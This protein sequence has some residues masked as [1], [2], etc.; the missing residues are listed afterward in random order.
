VRA[1]AAGLLV[2]FGVTAAW[3]AGASEPA[4]EP[5]ELLLW[6]LSRGASESYLLGTCHLG[7][8]LEHVLPPPHDAALSEASVVVTEV[9]LAAVRPEAMLAQA[10]LPDG[11]RLS[12]QVGAESWRAL[13][14][15]ARDVAPAP[16][17]DRLKPW[18]V[19]GA[20][21]VGRDE[22][23]NV[24][25]V[26]VAVIERATAAG[27]KLAY[28]ETPEEQVALMEQLGSR[29]F[30][31][32]LREIA[33]GVEGEERLLLR[34]ACVAGDL[35]AVEALVDAPA[36]GEHKSALYE[37]R[38][39]A[40]MPR[41]LGHLQGGQAFVAVGAGHLVG[42]RGLLSLL[43]R[44]GFRLERLSAPAAP[45]PD[46]WAPDRRVSS[47]LPPD[48][49][50]ARAGLW[51]DRLSEGFPEGVC[52][53]Q[54]AVRSCIVEDEAE[55]VLRVREGLA[56][57]VDQFAGSLPSPQE[58]LAPDLV[59]RLAGCAVSGLIAE[60]AVRGAAVEAPQCAA[61]V[62]LLGER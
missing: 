44:R 53:E 55:C 18:V 30:V 7:I 46:V 29:L 39:A 21:V 14:R 27:A 17:L 50:L 24:P 32:G 47:D 13:S 3:R 35:A 59:S 15:L 56:M 54:S 10:W 51:T 40:W 42:R 6:R 9:D 38:N 58:S 22:G 48:E 16:M 60:L 34:D 12:A 33:A 37:A 28:L 11:E 5:R 8:P 52:V 25:I 1:F 45:P 36:L 57:C 23:V 2:W 31:D 43:E 61:M 20:L 62:E 41:L 26:D 19:Y 4:E 49:L